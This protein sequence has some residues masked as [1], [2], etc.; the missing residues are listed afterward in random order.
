M[1]FRR[2]RFQGSLEAIVSTE[3]EVIPTRLQLNFIRL[4]RWNPPAIIKGE[5]FPLFAAVRPA[6]KRV[7]TSGRVSPILMRN[8]RARGIDGSRRTVSR[9]RSHRIPTSRRDKAIRQMRLLLSIPEVFPRDASACLFSRLWD[10]PCCSSCHSSSAVVR[11]SALK[12]ICPVC[13][14]LAVTDGY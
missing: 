10:R 4:A 13:I 14:L 1:P 6:G 9:T 5:F 3:A 7:Y 8:I 11:V 2:R 12:R